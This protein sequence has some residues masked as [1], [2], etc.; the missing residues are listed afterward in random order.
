MKSW[1][2]DNIIAKGG[3]TI[4]LAHDVLPFNE[5]SIAAD[6]WQ[7]VSLE[8]F[9][10]FAQWLKEKQNSKELWIETVGNITRYIME[11]DAVSIT[12][13][14]STT[15]KLVFSITDNL[16][17]DKFNFPL[18]IEV[19]VPSDW[20]KVTVKQKG[21]KTEI[22]VSEGKIIINAIPDKGNIDIIKTL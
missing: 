11:R 3:W 6:S 16:P 17:D 5:A 15:E 18:T 14:E 12:Q 19:K 21:P 9:E 2:S 22:I 20:K 1:I 8:S 7:P 4:Y 13:V 10:S